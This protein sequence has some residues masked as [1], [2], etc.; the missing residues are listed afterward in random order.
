MS[1]KG[2]TFNVVPKKIRENKANV[3]HKAE[4]PFVTRASP[5]VTH[6]VIYPVEKMMI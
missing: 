3:I 4:K 1:N 2:V 6:G 5:S